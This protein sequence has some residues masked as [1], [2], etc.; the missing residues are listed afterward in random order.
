MRD[1]SYSDVNRE[2]LRT[3]SPP[4]KLYYFLVG[5]CLIGVLYGCACWAYQIFTGM[6]VCCPRENVP[7][8]TQV[9]MSP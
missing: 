6:G 9:K 1:P 2:V 7:F 4:R 8:N 5:G 3:L